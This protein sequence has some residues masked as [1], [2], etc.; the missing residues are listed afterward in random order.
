MLDIKASVLV[1]AGHRDP[2][3]LVYDNFEV[4]MRWNRSENYA[5]AVG[6][7]ADRIAGSVPLTREADSGGERITLAQV[8]RLQQDLVLLGYDAGEA[9]GMFGPATRRALNR[10][11]DA[12]DMIADGHL[13]SEALQAVRKTAATM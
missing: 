10:F 2:I 6:R 9:D 7:L 13:S 11:Q 1:P 3:F 5:I 12:N 4:I 8:K